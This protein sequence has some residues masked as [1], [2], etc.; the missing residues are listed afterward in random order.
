MKITLFWIVKACN[1]V[2]RNRRLEKRAASNFRKRYFYHEDV[3]GKSLRNLY[4]TT[5]DN[6][7][8]CSKF[9]ATAVRPSHTV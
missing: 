3:G 2:N 1:L 4:R 8:D 6:I 9:I 7:Q 5:G